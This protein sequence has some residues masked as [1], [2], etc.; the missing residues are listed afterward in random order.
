M[1]LASHTCVR[2]MIIKG[3]IE[4]LCGIRSQ[5]AEESYLHVFPVTL[6]VQL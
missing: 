6:T 2:L 1:V 5:G 3:A 4:L